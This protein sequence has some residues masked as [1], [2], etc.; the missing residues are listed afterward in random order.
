MSRS[1]KKNPIEKDGSKE[2]RQIHHRKFRSKNKQRVRLGL[3]PLLSREVTNPY[4]IIDW[5]YTM[6]PE[7]IRVMKLESRYWTDEDIDV[8]Y[9]KF[10][11]K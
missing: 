11:T 9:R 1:F 4:D 3:E 7:E 10:I 6:F 8:I 5:I 2:N